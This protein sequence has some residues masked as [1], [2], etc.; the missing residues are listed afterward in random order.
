MVS[1]IAPHYLAVNAGSSSI[2]FALYCA[3]AAL[4]PVFHG[5]IAGIGGSQGCFNVQGGPGDSLTRRFVIPEHVTAVNVLL[6]WLAERVPADNLRAIA[7]RVVHGGA[8]YTSTHEINDSMLGDLYQA[9]RHEPGHLPQEIH[10]IEALRHRFPSTTHIACFDSSFH[11]SMPPAA[12]TLAIPHRFASAGVRRFGYHGLSCASMM[13]ELHRLGGAAAADGKVILA[14][15]GGGASITAVH[16]GLSQDTSMGLTPAGG[17][18]M[19]TRSGDIDPGL[20]WH[21]AR[22]EPMS[23][24]QLH[25]MLNHESG[26]LGVSGRSGDLR[27][28]LDLASEDERCAAAV[29]LFVYHAANTIGAMCTAIEGVDTL[30]FAGGVGE[31]SAEVRQRI[32]APLHY[33]GVMLDPG[34]N[35]AHGAIISSGASRVKVYVMRSD[36]Q[37]ILADEARMLLAAHGQRDAMRS[38]A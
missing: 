8:A 35:S 20:A 13:R 18:P 11:A 22:H 29:D 12:S 15:L 2:K 19:S 27:V 26:L 14:H 6:D 31:N 10:L 28:L 25:H 36:E 32:C 24:S 17:M 4:T 33:L 1:A 5:S 30:V 34:L 9:V 16:H 38:P 23:P 7:H 3:D 37:W 21:C